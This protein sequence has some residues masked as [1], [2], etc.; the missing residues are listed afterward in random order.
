[1]KYANDGTTILNE[2]TKTYQWMEAN[3]P[4]LGDGVTH[5]Y[6][7]GPVFVDDPNEVTEQQARWNPDEDTNVL[8]KDMGAVKGDEPQRPM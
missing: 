2:T 4:V 3:L 1:M 7:Q 8:E 6:H 5:Y